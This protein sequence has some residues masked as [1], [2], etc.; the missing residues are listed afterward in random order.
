MRVTIFSAGGKFCPACFD[1]YVVTRS[2]SSRLF[3]C[4]LGHIIYTKILL[5]LLYTRHSEQTNKQTTLHGM[6]EGLE[7]RLIE[8]GK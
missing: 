2:Y 7:T 8:C 6:W 3:L 4:A 5:C 1:F